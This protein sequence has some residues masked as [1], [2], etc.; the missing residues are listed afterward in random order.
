MS[1]TSFLQRIKQWFNNHT[2]GSGGFQS[3]PSKN[4]KLL[5]LTRRK[6]KKLSLTQ[7]YFQLHAKRLRPVINDKWATYVKTHPED[8]AGNSIPIEWR[9]K[10]IAKLFNEEPDTVKAEVKAHRDSGAGRVDEDE[11]DSV[12]A[13]EAD[14]DDYDV[15]ER[16][17]IIR[18]QSYQ[19]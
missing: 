7:A 14:G 16:L 4:L 15:T 11:G 5:K 13:E 1:L 2:R 12:K 18:A 8:W 6:T 19:E 9:N 17:R 3:R 10:L